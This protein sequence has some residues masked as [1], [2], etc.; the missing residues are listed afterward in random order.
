LV[1]KIAKSPTS[2]VF[3][4]DQSWG[5]NQRVVAAL[6]KDGAEPFAAAAGSWQQKVE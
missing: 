1:A 4:N 5:T 6:A 2:Q 3:P